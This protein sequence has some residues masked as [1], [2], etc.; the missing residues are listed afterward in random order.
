[1]LRHNSVDIVP[2]IKSDHSAI[3]LSIN[4]IQCQTH[5]PSFWKFNARL[6]DH[7]EYIKL[8][9]S[10]Y[11][12]WEEEG[13]EIQDPRVL[14]DFIKYKIRQETI[15][16]GKRKAR[17]RRANLHDL[18]K[19]LKSC[20]SLCDS[21]PSDENLSELDILHTEYDRHYEYIKKEQLYG[22]GQIGMNTVR[23]VTRIF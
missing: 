15:S 13:K 19:R 3:I 17:E 7:E 8:I 18:E 10:K 23:K 2:A 6:L 4:G 11:S 21:N 20:Q 9:N 12:E 16:Y 22:L 5:G 1:M 14:W